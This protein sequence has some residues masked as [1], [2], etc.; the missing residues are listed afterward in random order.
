MAETADKVRSFIAIGVRENL[1]AKLQQIE[2]QLDAALPA[3]SVKWVGP[4]QTHLTLK[5]LGEVDAA[6]LDELRAAIAE[7]CSGATPFNL[8]AAQLGCFPNFHRPRVVWIGLGGEIGKLRAL[9]A[10][11]E[12][13]AAG[14]GEREEQREFQPHLTIGR[15][16][17]FKPHDLRALEKTLRSTNVGVLDEWT[18]SEV[19]LFKSD[20]ASSGAVHT[21]LATFALG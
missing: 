20:L 8:N 13:G 11:I 7:A 4:A 14:F 9:Q 15:V 5:F 6:R 1:L 3:R 18:V 16:R 19:A 2:T 10:H 17:A 21:R 12:S